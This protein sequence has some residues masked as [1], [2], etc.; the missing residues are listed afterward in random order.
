MARNYGTHYTYVN[1]PLTGRPRRNKEKRELKAFWNS[2]AKKM[3]ALESM[4]VIIDD[5][6]YLIDVRE[7]CI[8]RL[9]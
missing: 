1:N 5:D 2:K 9:I 8:A 3:L 7:N 6:H 4:R